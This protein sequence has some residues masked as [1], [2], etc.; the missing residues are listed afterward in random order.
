MQLLC[1]PQAAAEALG[2]SR[3]TI[4]KMLADGRLTRRHVPGVRGSKILVGELERIARR[5]DQD[6]LLGEPISSGQLVALKA[7]SREYARHIGQTEA[8]VRETVLGWASRRFGREVES[9]KDL[10]W[11][12]AHELLD[13]LSSWLEGTEA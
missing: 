2:V 6:A 8:Q 3:R 4:D 7:K 10:S 12:E 1:T 9:S 11:Q 13:E 5:G